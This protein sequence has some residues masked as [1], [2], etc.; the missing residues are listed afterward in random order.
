MRPDEFLE[1]SSFFSS[2]LS[3]YLIQNTGFPSEGD[4]PHNIIIMKI[5]EDKTLKEGTVGLRNTVSILHN[6]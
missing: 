5:S 3:I 6:Y 2:L 4:D 1:D